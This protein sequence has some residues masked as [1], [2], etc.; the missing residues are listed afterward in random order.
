MA[1]QQH[2]SYC[3]PRQRQIFSARA[4]ILSRAVPGIH[5]LAARNA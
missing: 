4:A 2:N 5:V 1:E 3:L